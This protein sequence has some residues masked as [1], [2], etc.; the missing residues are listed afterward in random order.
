MRDVV[1]MCLVCPPNREIKDDSN[2]KKTPIIGFLT[3]SS[4]WR[5]RGAVTF[6]SPLT[7]CT[8]ENVKFPRTSGKATISHS[9]VMSRTIYQ[10]HRMK[11]LVNE[12]KSGEKSE[13]KIISN[14]VM[15]KWSVPRLWVMMSKWA[16]SCQEKMS[17]HQKKKVANLRTHI[18]KCS[19]RNDK[20]KT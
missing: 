15:C 3:S 12:M 2:L 5:R 10:V 16:E 20:K 19:W 8:S 17:R 1:G 11:I 6:G 14:F 4:T 18:K 13:V 9:L 7:I